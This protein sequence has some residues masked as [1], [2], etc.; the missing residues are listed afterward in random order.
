[1]CRPCPIMHA[2]A[3]A[4]P[5]LYQYYAFKKYVLPVLMVKISCNT[6]IS[7]YYRLA[8]MRGGRLKAWLCPGSTVERYTGSLWEDHCCSFAIVING[9]RKK[10]S[11]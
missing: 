5:M 7:S 3:Y 9:L 10:S 6:A 11:L 8:M 4:T 2:F 1:M